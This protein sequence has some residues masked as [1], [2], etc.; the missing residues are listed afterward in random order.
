MGLSIGVGVPADFILQAEGFYVPV[1]FPE[2][3]FDY[4]LL[5]SSQG[6]LRE[7]IYLAPFLGSLWEGIP[8]LVFALRIR[9]L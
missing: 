8:G 6:L 3:I 9:S 5:G 7:L 1:E 2:P 4:G